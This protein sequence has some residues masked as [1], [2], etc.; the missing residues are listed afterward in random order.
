[1]PGGIHR[2]AEGLDVVDH[3]RGGV[4]LHDQD[5]LDLVRGVRPEALAEGCRVDRAPPVALQDLGLNAHHPRHLTPAHGEPTAF[6]DEHRLPAGEHVADRRLPAAVTV[7][8]VV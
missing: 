1:M 7:G 5:R 6:Q 3:A 4:D 8:G 2:L